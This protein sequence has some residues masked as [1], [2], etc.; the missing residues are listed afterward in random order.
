LALDVLPLVA[1]LISVSHTFPRMLDYIQV[2]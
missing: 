1:F 2:P